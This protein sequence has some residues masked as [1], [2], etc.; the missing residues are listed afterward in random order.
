MV[1]VQGDTGKKVAVGCQLRV[2]VQGFWET[3]TVGMGMMM[4]V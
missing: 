1:F 3:W 2:L 4:H